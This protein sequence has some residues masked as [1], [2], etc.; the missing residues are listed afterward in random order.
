MRMYPGQARTIAREVI[1]EL[2]RSETIEVDGDL[3]GDA[4]Q[5]VESILLHYIRTDREINDEVRETIQDRGLGNNSFSRI[6]KRLAKE[7][8]FCFG[9]DA[10][11]WIV[12]QIIEMLLHSSN[13]E[14]VY[15]D[16][17][18]LRR[19]IGKCVK[20]HSADN[21]ENELDKAVRGKLKNLSE[22]STAWDVE[23]ERALGDLKRNKGLV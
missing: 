17:N 1:H 10:L 16:D 20:T 15:G 9:D 5:D 13:V 7:R 23:Y 14:E 3:L 11:E 22:G 19:V 4:E 12:D 2:T 8:D 21:T 18:D 6:K